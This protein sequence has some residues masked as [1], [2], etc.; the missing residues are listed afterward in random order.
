MLSSRKNC[1]IYSLS[2]R[3]F[4]QLGLYTLRII[5]AQLLLLTS[6]FYSR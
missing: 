1:A 2:I 5:L 3:L 4:L 6:K